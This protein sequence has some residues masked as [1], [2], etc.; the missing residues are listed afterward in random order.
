[1]NKNLKLG[2][3]PTV[4]VILL[5]ATL[6]YSGLLNSKDESE[7][8]DNL[9]SITLFDSAVL[10]GNYLIQATNSDG[11]FVYKYNASI[12]IAYSSY[13]ILRHSGTIYSMLQLYNFTKDEELLKAAEKAIEY[14]FT[15]LKPYENCSIIVEDDEVKLGG[16][17][18]GVVALVEHSIVTGKLDYLPIM[19]N[20]T[21]FIKYSQLQNGKFV[22]KRIYS[23][24][25]IV[26][27]DSEYYPGEAILALCRMYLIDKNETWLNVAEDG[28][29]YL[30]NVR[31]AAKP[32]D[33]L[34]H[35]HWLL[36]ALNELYRYRLDP[37]YF[38][39]SMNLS[40]GII[41]KQRDGINR[42]TEISDWLGSYY[43][44][45][46]S[47]STATRT[48]GLIAAFN[49][50]YD[51]G[52]FEMA[53]KIINAIKLGITFQ[54]KTQFNNESIDG[55]PNPVRAIGGFKHRLDDYIIRIDYVQHNI[56]SILGYY[57]IL[58]SKI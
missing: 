47:T 1:M 50:A 6:F 37:L 54:L 26:D 38:D 52:D 11:S 29:K 35:D 33:E 19:Q 10:G 39:H 13:N 51:Y 9:I 2:G 15:F 49:L 24:D 20:L 3:L 45:P 14:L 56:C 46:G 44:P 7:S 48:E 12:D 16:A 8:V 32:I 30:I 53:D 31:D 4:I 22:S 36:M 17:A 57:N 18:L 21:K 28:A 27:W 58:K 34:I 25:E 5:I 43:T 42:I 41:N 40:L 55:L 23:T